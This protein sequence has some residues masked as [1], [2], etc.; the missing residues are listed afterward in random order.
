[1]EN[2]NRDVLMAGENT[3]YAG[4]LSKEDRDNAFAQ[5]IKG[6]YKEQFQDRFNREFKRRFKNMKETEEE[7]NMIKENLAPLMEYFGEKDVVTLIGLLLEYIKNKENENCRKK[8]YVSNQYADWENE[9]KELNTK[10]PGFDIHNELKNP[11]FS[12]GLRA[13][14]PM[15]YLYRGMHFDELSEG[16]SEAAVRAAIENI[17]S[18]NGRIKESGSENSVPVKKTK[19]VE[20]LTGEEIENIIDRVRRGEKISFGA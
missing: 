15:S 11:E 19:R 9:A 7:L 4:D 2:Y 16:I 5:L 20:D 3:A 1:M 12:A 14:I 6:M 18:G 10:Y 8:E 13:G 17:R